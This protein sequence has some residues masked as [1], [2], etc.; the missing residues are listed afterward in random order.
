MAARGVILQETVNR[1]G[2]LLDSVERWDLD[3]IGQKLSA[4][5]PRAV[6][7]FP[8]WSWDD[9]RVSGFKIFMFFKAFRLYFLMFI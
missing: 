2:R 7:T 1:P 4:A 8:F 5:A 9:S 6:Q 3:Q